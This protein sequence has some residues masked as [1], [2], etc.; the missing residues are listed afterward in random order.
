M[1]AETD[2]ALM[3]ARFPRVWTGFAIAGLFA[4]TEVLLVSEGEGTLEEPVLS[5]NSS[6]R[7][8]WSEDLSDDAVMDKEGRDQASHTGGRGDDRR[9]R[10]RD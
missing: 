6:A 5:K 4:L 9:V 10:P 7:L 8:R 2:G 3:S 1:D